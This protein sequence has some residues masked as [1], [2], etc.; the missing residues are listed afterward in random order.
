MSQIKEE[1]L[2]GAVDPEV[3]RRVWERVMARED[4]GSGAEAQPHPQPRTEQLPERQP[5]IE[6][7]AEQKPKPVTDRELLEGG[8]EELVWGLTAVQTLIR[9]AGRRGQALSALAADYRRMSRQLSAAC[10]L[11]TGQ[12]RRPAARGEQ[13]PVELAQGL[14]ELFWWERRWTDRCRAASDQARDHFVG[15]LFRRM[16]ETGKIHQ[17]MILGILEEMQQ[18]HLDA[19]RRRGVN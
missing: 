14:R 3:F 18:P 6:Q 15:E 5:A 1:Q 10:F 11:L 8:L 2:G 12:E 7:P 19:H 13:P 4:S 16:Y 9:R 17:G